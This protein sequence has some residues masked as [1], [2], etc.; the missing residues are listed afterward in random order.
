MLK[1][2][3][4][5]LLAFAEAKIF[6]YSKNYQFLSVPNG[7]INATPG[8][9]MGV[10][11][12]ITQEA[13]DTA[14]MFNV[15][16]SIYPG[17]A[18]AVGNIYQAY[19]QFEGMSEFAYSNTVCNMIFN[20]LKS[21]YTVAN[22]CGTTLFYTLNHTKYSQIVGEALTCAK[23]WTKVTDGTAFTIDADYN[24]KKVANCTV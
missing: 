9:E 11:F 17:T 1:F 23:P 10:T 15:L 20:N 7:T 12:T 22:S 19:V 5:V 14:M 8:Y 24:N 18:F 16:T 2:S 13:D 6:P 4:C 3:V 21:T